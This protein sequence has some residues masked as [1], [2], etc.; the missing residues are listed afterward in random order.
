M[1]LAVEGL[2]HR[3]GTDSD[4]DGER[5]RDDDGAEDGSGGDSDGN[6]DGD[7][8]AVSAV[9]FSIDAGELVAL[10]GPSGCGKTT[11]VQSVAGHVR[12]TG[13]TV[14]LRGVDVTDSPPERRRVGLVFQRSALFPHMTVAENVAYGLR[15]REIDADRREERVDRYLDLVEVAGKRDA[16]PDELS[17]GQRRRVELARVLVPEPDVLLLDEP[18]SALDRGLRD[19]L[20]GEIVR[21]QRETGVTTL[22]VTHDQ[23]EAMALADRLVL[24]NRGRVAGVGRPRDLYES[25]PTPFVAS[26]LGRS[27]TLSAT[28]T[29]TDPL[30]VAIGG[31]DVR[32]EHGSGS[33]R[34]GRPDR[35]GRGQGQDRGQGFT[36]GQRVCCHVRPEHVALGVPGHGDPVGDGSNR[37]GSGRDRSDRD[38]SSRESTELD[39]ADG[40]DGADVV[41]AGSVT[42]VVDVGKRYDVTVRLDTGE[43]L[44]TERVAEPP[45]FEERT[46]VGFDATRLTAFE[47]RPT[48]R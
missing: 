10:V 42:N 2:T 15:A 47:R 8:P 12:P 14:R 40:V 11:V 44:L 33:D 39:G 34:P 9:S 26:F 38:G 18:L 19:R 3:Y 25:P 1:T 35:S 37:G 36:T 31:H 16:V 13:G 46:T 29:G 30:T 28:V 5:D 4:G 7:T 24:M 20:R 17:G 41:L 43:E 27:S 48:D 45:A 32:L 22:F 23:E 21:I 6:G